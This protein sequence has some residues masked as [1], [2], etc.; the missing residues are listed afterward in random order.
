MAWM[1]GNYPKPVAYLTAWEYEQGRAMTM[2]G[3]FP[4]GWFN[5]YQ[6]KYSSEIMMNM[7]FWLSD[8]PLIDDIEVY[9]RMK[10]SFSEFRRRIGNLIS[11]KEFIAR[12]GANTQAIDREIMD[13]E[14]IYG[15]ASEHYLDHDFVESAEVINR[16]LNLFSE[17]EDVA[18]KE[19]EKAL[20]W[21]YAIEW[22]VSSSALF[23]SGFVLWT[24][25]VRRRLYKDVRTTKLA[26]KEE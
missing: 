7:I 12:F 24:L 6:N 1:V 20:M 22:L 21:V 15:E 23:I 26:Y 3:L 13:L 18:R 11:L 14:E 19:K 5:Y 10:S 17:A 4:G 8:T 9:H 2:G 16:G 25:M